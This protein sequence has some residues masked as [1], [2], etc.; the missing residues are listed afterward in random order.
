MDL[1]YI[2]IA[3]ALDEKYSLGIENIF[4]AVGIAYNLYR[5][6]DYFS[7]Q[8]EGHRYLALYNLDDLD[9]YNAKKGLDLISKIV[10]CDSLYIALSLKTDVDLSDAFCILPKNV[11]DVKDIQYRSDSGSDDSAKCQKMIEFYASLARDD[12]YDVLC[13]ALDEKA[14]LFNEFYC[15]KDKGKYTD[16]VLPEILKEKYEDIVQPC[17]FVSDAQFQ[18]HLRYM[19]MD[20]NQ[21]AD[22]LRLRLYR[23][24]CH[25]VLHHLV[26]MERLN[27]PAFCT[28]CIRIQK[29]LKGEL[30]SLV[31]DEGTPKDYGQLYYE[32]MNKIFKDD[33]SIDENIHKIVEV[34]MRRS[35]LIY[36]YANN[37]IDVRRV[38]KERFNI[39]LD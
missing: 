22:Y 26:K 15:Y 21:Y 34:L 2:K 28:A 4:R 5:A 24:T 38:A 3:N 11:V 39:N 23:V 20:M 18:M 25:N 14:D 8:N 37:N 16:I 1:D 19:R 35:S 33:A 9:D 12:R 36:F 17:S 27:G 30:V 10:L 31:F 13:E 6:K 29:S 7:N 32:Y